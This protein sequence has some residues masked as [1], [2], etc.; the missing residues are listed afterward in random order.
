MYFYRLKD[1]ELVKI[2]IEQVTEPDEDEW[3]VE[4]TR[5]EHL[6]A[7]LST[8]LLPLI[9]FSDKVEFQIFETML[10]VG[11]KAER[12]LGRYDS[13]EEASAAHSRLKQAFDTFDCSG[14]DAKPWD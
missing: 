11:G 5:F 6:D 2:D 7:V 13:Y 1:K 14:T 10:F 4:R 9:H 8:V 3:L 12:I